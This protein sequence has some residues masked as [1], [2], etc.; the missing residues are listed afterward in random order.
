M[1][2]TLSVVILTD[3]SILKIRSE[4]LC[5][6]QKKLNNKQI[7]LKNMIYLYVFPIEEFNRDIAEAELKK[8]YQE[9]KNVER[10]TLD[11]F[12]CAIN[13]DGFNMNTHWVKKM[14]DHKYGYPISY[15]QLDDLK[16]LGFDTD[17]VTE[18]NLSEIA[19]RLDETYRELS[20]WIC[21]KTIAEDL[22]ISKVKKSK[23]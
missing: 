8:A 11:E 13:D 21:L 6:M 3:N 2:K 19:E 5:K 4:M 22:G 15:L 20:Y 23:K 7:T 1:T 9:C 10:Y 16:E 12:I 17:K 14:D 18:H